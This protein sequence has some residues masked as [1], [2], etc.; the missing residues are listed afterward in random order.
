MSAAPCSSHTR[1][2]AVSTRVP[3]PLETDR[4]STTWTGSRS[5]KVVAAVWA[6]WMVLDSWPEMVRQT[7]ASA[8][9]RSAR[10]KASSKAPGEGQAVWG[11]SVSFRGGQ[12][13]STDSGSLT[14]LSR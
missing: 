11:S 6:D 7:T 14:V 3:S 5:A 13:T 12:A 8:P 1:R 10:S 4:L 2:A 9:A